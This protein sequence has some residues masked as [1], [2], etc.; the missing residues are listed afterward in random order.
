M[1]NTRGEQ[2]EGSQLI[3]IA[4]MAA[5]V[6][7]QAQAPVPPPTLRVEPVPSFAASRL[8]TH[9]VNEPLTP[10]RTRDPRAP[11]YWMIACL[12]VVVLAMTAYAVLDEPPMIVQ[13]PTT[14]TEEA[15]PSRT[16]AVAAVD[17]VERPKLEEMVEREVPGAPKKATPVEE[18]DAKTDTQ[19][20]APEPAPTQ[21]A[22]RKPAKAAA[23]KPAPKK[24]AEPAPTKPVTTPAETAPPPAK[25]DVPIECILDPA[26]CG[27]GKAP[28]TEA[29]GPRTKAPAED[30][31]ETLSQSALRDGFARVKSAAKA[32]GPKHGAAAGVNV[33]VKLSIAG[34]TGKVIASTPLGSHAKSALGTC[35]ADALS[36]ATFDR[37]A[38]SQI[39][40]KYTVRL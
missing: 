3:D 20:S 11:L 14:A 5:L 36:G 33:E 21:T 8:T 18:D 31:P 32:C 13:A 12:N 40:L 27:S 25:K 9:V 26:S 38:K 7:P 22:S 29:Q 28:T 15:K 10:A 30:L 6:K 24:P 19:P 39:G 34:G 4:N 1:S 37:F 17:R 23:S 35:V 2:A 16:A